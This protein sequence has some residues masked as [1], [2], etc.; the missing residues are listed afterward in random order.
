[1]NT[2]KITVITINLN[3]KDGL[4]K[5]L[6]S[7]SYQTYINFEYIV[8]DGNSNDGSLKVIEHNN[9]TIDK[10]IVE[11]DSGIYDAMNKGISASTGDYLLFI[12]SGDWLVSH[13]TLEQLSKYALDNTDIIYGDII[14]HDAETQSTKTT[15]YPEELSFQYFRY[16][17]LPHQATL[18]KR[19]L[20]NEIGLYDTNMKI[21]SDWAFF[22]LAIC[23]YQK[24]YK[25]IPLLVCNFPTDGIGSTQIETRRRE[26]EYFLQDNFKLFNDDYRRFDNIRGNFFVKIINRFLK[27]DKQN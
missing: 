23:K 22:C 4:K 27:L 20:F 6:K 9:S 15:N 1:M 10:C 26:R 2:P 21:I 5:T 13:N 3:N 16:R 17:T 14:L 11:K 18:I 25:K 24:K 7:I 8:V 19:E 12:N